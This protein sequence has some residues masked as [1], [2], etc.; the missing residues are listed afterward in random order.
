[1]TDIWLQRPERPLSDG[2]VVLRE[3]REEDVSAIV[4]ICQD[5]EVARF[6]RVPSPYTEQDARAFLAGEVMGHEMGFAIVSAGN[7][8]EVLGSIGLHDA[9]ER[10]GQIGYLVAARARRRGVA[11][12]ALRLLAEWAL[13]EA[14][15]P[16]VQLFTR[17]DNPASQRTA[18]RAGFRRE[19]V[20]RSHMLIK[21]ERYD[22]VI[23]GLI[24]EDVASA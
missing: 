4:E 9:G 24:A 21:G 14:G 20:L 8:A 16:R 1:V 10:R 15:L 5:P 2:V 12:R 17:V 11:S 6:T 3:W 18:E 23:F 13:T 22:A 19:G 7:E